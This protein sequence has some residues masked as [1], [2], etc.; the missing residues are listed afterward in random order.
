MK[1]YELVLY[2]NAIL[3]LGFCF[4]GLT[5]GI[6]FSHQARLCAAP[7]PDCDRQ[8]ALGSRA[9]DV[10]PF[11]G[12]LATILAGAAATSTLWRMR[13]PPFRARA[14]SKV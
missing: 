11:L 3:F 4:F 9:I 10:A 6:M 2:A 7:S 13:L 5:F 12:A 14:E 1:G 8:A